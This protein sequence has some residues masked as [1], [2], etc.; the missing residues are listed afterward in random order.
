MK[1]LFTFPALLCGAAALAAVAAPVQPQLAH[2]AIPLLTVNGLQFRDLNRNG[3]LDPYEDWRLPAATRAASLAAALSLEEQ[4]GL[5]MHGTLVLAQ[6]S[7]AVD[8]QAMSGLIQQRYI[9]TFISRQQGDAATLANTYNQLQQLAET[10]RWAIPVSL[11]TDPRNHFQHVVGQSVTSGGFSQWPEPLG[12]AAINDAALTRRFGDI[13]RQEYLAVGF[14]QALS[15]Q[16]D[17][18]TEPRWSRIFSTFGEDADIV[19]SQV[20]AYVA[21]FQHG[22]RGLAP[23]SVAAVVK[24]WAGYGAAKDGWDS[25]NPY[26]KFMTFPSKNFAYHLKPFDGAFAA[27]AASIMPTYSQPDGVVQINGITLDQVGGGYSKALLTDL[28]RNKKK[29]K[30]VVL[31]DWAIT[32]DC[33][34]PCLDGA[35][36]GVTP[37]AFFP[38]FGTPWGVED[39]DKQARFAKGVMAGIDQF[40]GTEESQYLVQAVRSGAVPA[41]RLQ[42]S[43]RRILLQKFQQGLFENP[44][45]DVAAA[46]ATLGKPEFSAAALDAQRRSLVLLQ[47]RNA[48]L[49]LS[50][51]KRRVYLHGI[52]PAIAAGYGFTVVDTPEQAELAII[53]A[54]TPFEP[55][56]PRYIF[57]TLTHE[58]TLAYADGNAD[59]EAI[60]RASA[61]V[62]TIV[63]VNLERPAILTNVV[64]KTAAVLANFGISDAALFDVLTG[65]AA[66][67]GR[68]PVE[69]P[70][71][72]EAVLNQRSDLPHDS[73]KPLFPFGFGLRYALAARH[74]ESK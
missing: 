6:N 31:S 30:G 54:A 1:H 74:P 60:K 45:V 5:M 23:G 37:L 47:N 70:S 41:A 64:D 38:Q 34:G 17:L 51:A 65:K 43:V 24:H 55:L 49:P 46:K 58:G 4:A 57:G 18:A 16:A 29:F 26:G 42:E 56:H 33:K 11:S 71:S 48:L 36:E 7:N 12:L 59:Y 68:L 32:N 50:G 9:N 21:G 3:K 39:L 15:P 62:P 14:T 72:M 44:Y 53:R 66:P 22:E 52:D 35:P 28:L 63:T 10:T 69:L 61:V 25:H 19:K 27:Q 13:A 8:E 2:G 73:V 20:R 67:Q 40:G